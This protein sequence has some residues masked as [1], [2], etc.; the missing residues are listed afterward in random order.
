MKLPKPYIAIL[1][2]WNKEKHSTDIIYFSLK[3]TKNAI[4]HSR[5]QFIYEKEYL[6]VYKYLRIGRSSNFYIRPRTATENL[7]DAEYIL[8]PDTD[9]PWDNKGF[10]EYCS[11]F[12]ISKPRLA[13]VCWI[14]LSRRNK[15]TSLEDDSVKYKGNRICEYCI[16]NELSQELQKSNLFVS[17]GLTRFFQQQAERETRTGTESRRAGG[18]QHVHFFRA[19]PACPGRARQG[20]RVRSGESAQPV[21]LDPSQVV[22]Q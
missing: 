20:V 9:Q 18:V 3:N 11:T 10:L 8:V 4:V 5:L 14:C 15:W 17:G 19:A 16:K 2:N 22:P 7:R 1:F 13:K 6:R 21:E 12:K